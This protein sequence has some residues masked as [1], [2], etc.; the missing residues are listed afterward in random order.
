MLKNPSILYQ[1][2]L[3]NI[4]TDPHTVT[5]TDIITQHTSPLQCSKTHLFFINTR[6]TTT[7]PQTPTQSL[8]Q[9]L[10]H[11]ILHHSNAQKPIYSLSTP[12]TQHSHRTP[13][14]HYNR[15]NHTTY[16]TTPMLKNPSILYQHTLHNNIPT[17]PHTVTITDIITQHTSP[18]QCSKKHLF[19]INTRY[20]TT[21][22]QTPTQSL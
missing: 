7:F 12:V 17:D 13:H 10:S 6:Y 3:H 18:L 5:T 15:H 19:F 2:P 9:A 8:Q 4:P 16:L 20:T 11:N 1:H 14:S 22:P 21:F